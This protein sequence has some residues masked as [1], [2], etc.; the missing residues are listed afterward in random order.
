M[1]KTFRTD[2]ASF[3]RV[4]DWV[5]RPQYRTELKRNTSLDGCVHIAG[6][7]T[8][9]MLHSCV[10]IE[11]LRSCVVSSVLLVQSGTSLE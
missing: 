8:Q 4:A 2:F 1:N 11:V 5:G 7:H 6:R 10:Y 9:L 3:G